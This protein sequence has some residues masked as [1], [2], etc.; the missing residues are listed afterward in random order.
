MS[1]IPTW[2]IAIGALV[3]GTAAGVAV[4][5][6]I[7]SSRIDKIK[8]TNAEEITAASVVALADYR[9]A[10]EEIKEAATGAKADITAVNSQLATIRRNQK[11][12][13]LPSLPADCKPGS[14]RLRN[15]AETA[16]AADAAIARPVPGK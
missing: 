11:N 14:V 7:M 1:L 13:P 6:A 2:P 5:H 10:A 3:L 16:A 12:V 15:L 8:L 9:L 4:D